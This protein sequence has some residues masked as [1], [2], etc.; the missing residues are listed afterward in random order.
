MGSVYWRH[1]VNTTEPSTCGSDA[2][3][4]SNY[5][6]DLLLRPRERLGSIVMGMS[7]C[8]SVCLSV[9]EDISGTTRAIFTKIF[10]HVAYHR[11]PVLLRH[12][13]DR[14][15]RLSAAGG[16]DLVRAQRG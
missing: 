13:Y 15:H 3:F 12:V 10:M 9:R 16:E 4:L 8:L 1:L 14:P 7:V 5:F 6:E 11:G 2:A